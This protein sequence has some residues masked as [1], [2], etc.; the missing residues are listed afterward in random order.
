M[1]DLFEY[2]SFV[3]KMD[4]QSLRLVT[5]FPRRVITMGKENAMSSLDALG[6]K[7]GREVFMAEMA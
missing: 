7:A 2:A 3:S 5:S 1:K 4:G 6:I